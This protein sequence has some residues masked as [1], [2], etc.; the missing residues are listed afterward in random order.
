MICLW[1]ADPTGKNLIHDLYSVV[2]A[3]NQKQT[4]VNGSHFH[5]DKDHRKATDMPMIP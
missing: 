3:R 1:S 5:R 4:M 2:T